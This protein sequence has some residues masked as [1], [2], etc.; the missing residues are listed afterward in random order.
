M[1]IGC[2]LGV[3]V[4]AYLYR[5]A[6]GDWLFFAS[7]QPAERVVNLAKSAKLTDTG[8]RLL[9]RGDPQFVGI[10][11]IESVCD[12]QELGC[13]TPKGQIYILDDPTNQG[14]SVITALHEMLHLAYRRLPESAKAGL[15][16]ELT[17]VQQDP[18]LEVEL[19]AYTNSEERRDEAFAIAGTEIRSLPKGLEEQYQR[20]FQ[21]REQIVS[22]FENSLK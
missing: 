20:Y 19:K 7:H 4:V 6:L 9:Y 18:S 12:T 13:L 3:L 10:A 22:T 11:T 5:V 8:T 21:D 14:Q 16:Y 15:S 2:L 17:Q 1:F